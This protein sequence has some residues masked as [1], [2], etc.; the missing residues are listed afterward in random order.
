MKDPVNT[1][2]TFQNCPHGIKTIPGKKIISTAEETGI[3]NS[4]AHFPV[5]MQFPLLLPFLFLYFAFFLPISQACSK[6]NHYVPR[7]FFTVVYH[8]MRL[9]YTTGGV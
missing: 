6:N 8:V 3:F 2:F 4:F 1:L 7:Y 9:S 5:A